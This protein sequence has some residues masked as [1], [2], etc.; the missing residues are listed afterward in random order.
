MAEQYEK[1]IFRS[2]WAEIKEHSK[3]DAI[4]VIADHI[5]LALAAKAIVENDTAKVREWI[6]NKDI[7]K[8][9]QEQLEEWAANE[10]KSFFF[11]IAQPY[12]LI[13]EPKLQ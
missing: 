10:T 4:I 11:F 6:D 5:P 9:T 3:R 13:Q 7:I 1:Q 2:S 12:V 8:P